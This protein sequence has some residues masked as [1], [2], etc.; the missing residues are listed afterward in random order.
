MD[1]VAYPERRGTVPGPTPAASLTGTER[2]RRY[3]CSRLSS[4]S[5]WHPLM[6]LAATTLS[7]P[8]I[9]RTPEAA[10]GQAELRAATEPRGDEGGREHLRGL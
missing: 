1:N 10:L 5:P 9:E 2:T 6:A 8:A 3:T 7:T 4:I